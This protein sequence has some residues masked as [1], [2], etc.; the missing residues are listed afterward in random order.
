MTVSP[1]T[2]ATPMTRYLGAQ[3]LSGRTPPLDPEVVP[4]HMPFVYIYARKG[5]TTPQNVVG[6]SRTAMYGAESFD[7]LHKWA[8]HATMYANEFN[9]EGNACFIQRLKPVDAGPPASIRLYLDLL[10]TALPN[11][12]RNADGTYRRD[13]AGALI[14]TNTTTPGMLAKITRD[15][16]TIGE[17]GED[18]FGLADPSVGTMVDPETSEQSTRWPLMDIRCADF[19][20]D[21]HNRALRLWAPTTRSN[22]PIDTTLIT[23]S[24]AYPMRVAIATRVNEESTASIYNTL[25]AEPYLDICFKP[26]AYNRRT[27]K[28]AY[29]QDVFI[30]SY[31][32]YTTDGTP[33][34]LAPFGE[35]HVY[36]NT[37][38]QILPDLVEAEKTLISQYAND[39]K[40]GAEVD[41]EAFLFNFISAQTSAGVP[42][43]SYR[44]VTG[45][46]DSLTLGEN[47][48]VFAAGSSDGT[49]NDEEFSKL[50]IEQAREWA[51]ENSPLQ[52][53]LKYPVSIF[54]DSG[55]SMDAKNAM[56]DFIS[57]RKD[58]AY[59]VCTHVVGERAL[60]PSEEASRAISLRARAENF[61]ES[62]F[63][64][65]S[66]MRAMVAAQ[67]GDLLDTLYNKRLPLSIQTARDAAGY[68]G[69]ANGRW[70]PGRNFNVY[71]RN[72]IT[73]LTNI[74]SPWIPAKARQANWANGLVA[75]EAFD[76]QRY[77]FPALQTVYQDDTSIFNSFMTMLACTQ[78]QKIGTKV[79]TELTG[80]D[81]L[82]DAQ[83]LE[84][85]N[86]KVN[87]KCLGRF[88]NR[89]IIT[90]NA[91]MTAD[92]R[93]RGYSWHLPIFLQA[94]PMRTVQTLYVVGQRL[95]EDL[96]LNQ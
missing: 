40:A 19:G 18:S 64:G 60:T 12:E 1:I 17:D 75:A 27:N 56:F 44:L 49:M 58:L 61:P 24:Q 7:P 37:L 52:S 38:E 54:W 51:D 87:E 77:F 29:L 6:G 43:F 11:Y 36:A 8:N 91:T 57:L 68:M 46:A 62:E 10:P 15:I 31:Q 42:Y 55:L 83:F 72:I 22:N 53:M 94:G 90:P 26:G 28:Q 9:A 67:S 66:V 16:V 63:F 59:V 93:L 48:N 34:G 92:D 95:G 45:E 85:V 80:T 96:N 13:Q 82:T 23:L 25:Q 86:D 14:P 76:T 65:T 89:Y 39:F 74:S 4:Q 79:W 47:Y 73:R 84:R 78:L 71:P 70:T 69:A 5:L 20:S 3:D 21:G 32:Q 41:A 2:T 30:K 81:D 33:S 35:I 50:V 88:D